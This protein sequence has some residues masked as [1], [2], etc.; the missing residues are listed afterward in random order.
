MGTGMTSLLGVTANSIILTPYPPQLGTDMALSV[1]LFNSERVPANKVKVEAFIGDE[2]LGEAKVDVPVAQPV[3][4][5][6]FKTWKA[7]QGRYDVRVVVSWADRSGSASKPIEIGSKGARMG[8]RMGVA[9]LI[10]RASFSMARLLV[11]AADVRLNPVAPAAG[12]PVELSV[13]AMNSGNADA[14]GVRV[15]LFAD[16]VKLG[17][18]TGDIEIGKDHI[19]TGF[20]RWTPAAGRHVLLCRATVMGQTTEVTREVTTGFTAVMVSPT[21]MKQPAILATPETKMA[22]LGGTLMMARLERP[23]LQITPADITYAPAMP[24]AGDALTITIRVQ[25]VGTAT[26]SG[27]VTGV[28]QVDGAESARRDFPVSIGPGGMM[29]LVW[30]VTTPSGSTLMAVATA[31]VANDAQPGNNEG[32]ASTSILRVIQKLEL[33]PE[34][35]PRLIR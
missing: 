8:E 26:A 28:L 17:E 21:I 20:P 29:S 1:R 5:T 15:E 16:Q 23:D 4:A 25:N 19:F 24:K 2:K 14:K 10:G 3:I 33:P 12:Q 30:P 11:T 6:G 32:R 9:S 7:K 13:R 27:T 34:S 35:Q 31:S 18:A 22:P